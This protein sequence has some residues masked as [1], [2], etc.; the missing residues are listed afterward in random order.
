MDAAA[1]ALVNLRITPQLVN[2]VSATMAAFPEMRQTAGYIRI[3]SGLLGDEMAVSLRGVKTAKV[4]D[5]TIAIKVK[6]AATV[7]NLLKMLAKIEEPTYQIEDTNVYVV[8]K[9]DININIAVAGEVLVI[10]PGEEDLKAALEAF[11]KEDVSG[12]PAD[13]VNRGVYG[14]VNL[15]GAKASEAGINIPNIKDVTV[16]LTMGIDGPWRE[17]VITSPGGFSGLASMLEEML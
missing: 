14:F 15:D 12:A 6:D 8:E 4:P 17:L 3:A 7:P 13:I 9:G 11:S 16:A 5:A 1:P 10:T 2:A